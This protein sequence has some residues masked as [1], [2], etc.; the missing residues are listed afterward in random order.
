MNFHILVFQNPIPT[1]TVVTNKVSEAKK[2]LEE[3]KLQEVPS[4]DLNAPAQ[5][6][7]LMMST[8]NTDERST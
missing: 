3:E 7:P 4:V 1:S 2:D 6:T 5:S 8:V